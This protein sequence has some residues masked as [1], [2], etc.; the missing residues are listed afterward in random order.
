MRKYS[1]KFWLIFWTCSGLFLFGW[2]L[3]WNSKNRGLGETAS[4]IIGVFPSSESS[5]KQAQS[6]A[7]LGDYFLAGK[8]RTLLVLFQNNLEI[9]PGGGFLG[10]FAIVK[11]KNGRIISMETH[12]LSNFDKKI[13]NTIAPPYPMKE[14]GYVDFWKMRDSNFSPDFSVDAKKAQEFYALG[15]GQEKID[16][17]VGVT[18]NML[19]S[20]LKITGPIQVEDFPGTYSS[21]NAIISLEYQVEKAFEQQGITRGDRKS[22][23]NELAK[24]IEKRVF[25]FSISQKI[26]LAKILIADLGKKDIQLYFKDLNLQKKIQAAGWAGSV[27]QNWNKDFLLI[28]D[29]NLGSFKSDYYVKRSIDYTVDLTKQAP[30]A[31]LKITYQHTAKQKDW[32]TRDYVDYLR[33][34]VPE[35]SQFADQQNLQYSNIGEEFGKKY[36]DG[37]VSVPIDST[38]VVEIS[39]SLPDFVRNNYSLKIQKQAG[40]NDIPV[41]LHLT[42]PDGTNANF[43]RIMNSDIVFK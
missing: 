9:R 8:E 11:I 15:G 5:K 2:F 6:L 23:M 12:D 24:E 41:S 30:E 27:D 25:A 39:Y 21:E 14:I 40:L 36:F 29:A 33:V 38:K 17:V 19:T 20:I 28:V 7:T 18:A 26:Q 31:H 35:N 4:Q 22:V 37:A 3:F 13:P 43:S 16:G 10:A 1:L 34:Y 32:M 42:R